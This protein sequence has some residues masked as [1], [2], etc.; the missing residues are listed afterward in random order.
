M[1]DNPFDIRRKLDP[2]GVID[3]LLKQISRQAKGIF[4]LNNQLTH[5]QAFLTEVGVDYTAPLPEKKKRGRTKKAEP[6]S[7][8]PVEG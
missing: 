7:S 4:D 3:D 1:S 2:Q 6:L 5:L 8:E